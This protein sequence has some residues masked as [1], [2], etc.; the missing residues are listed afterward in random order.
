MVCVPLGALL[1]IVVALRPPPF[2]QRC[3][4][5]LTDLIGSGSAGD[6]TSKAGVG[7]TA[8]NSRAARERVAKDRRHAAKPLNGVASKSG[9]LTEPLHDALE[10]DEQTDMDHLPRSAS[11]TELSDTFHSAV[12]TSEGG[13]TEDHR[14]RR[15][16]SLSSSWDNTC[17]RRRSASPHLAKQQNASQQ[18]GGDG[19]SGGLFTIHYTRTGGRSTGEG[20]SDVWDRVGVRSDGGGSTD[21]DDDD[22]DRDTVALIRVSKT[23][24]GA[25]SHADKQGG[26]RSGGGGGGGR[27][28]GGGGCGE[29]GDAALSSSTQATEDGEYLESALLSPDV[30]LPGH[31]SGD[32]DG[33]WTR[34]FD[35]VFVISMAVAF[36]ALVIATTLLRPGLWDEPAFGLSLLAKLATMVGVS[37]LGGLLCRRFCDVDSRGYILTT[38]SSWF[39]VNYT[40]KLQHFAAYLVSANNVGECLSFA[41]KCVW[42]HWV[43][44][45]G[46]CVVVVMVVVGE[47]LTV[48]LVYAWKWCCYRQWQQQRWWQ[49]WW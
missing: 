29:H 21:D 30:L 5:P 46:E 36:T 47:E 9:G 38:T 37:S 34:T 17:T 3:C 31:V 45:K 41:Q 25:K 49:G 12:A 19:G 23:R 14:H 15:S 44:G 28:R 32:Y 40:R 6:G 43:G 13:A 10:R 33:L 11:S 42:V 4:Q 1:L 27:G 48:V 35:A 26:Q 8:P 22:N 7:S 18:P 16:S 39:K 20:L 24:N 2:V